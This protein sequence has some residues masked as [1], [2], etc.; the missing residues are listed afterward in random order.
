[1]KNVHEGVRCFAAGIVHEM[2]ITAGHGR[3]GMPQQLGQGEFMLP[4]KSQPAGVCVA[5]RVE[6]P[7]AGDGP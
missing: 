4:C 5:Q 2:G 3:A 1:M 7:R 6:R